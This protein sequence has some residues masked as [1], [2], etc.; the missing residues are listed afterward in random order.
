MTVGLN[1]PINFVEFTPVKER[2]KLIYIV[3]A[4]KVALSCDTIQLHV[5]KHINIE[6]F[7]KPYTVSIRSFAIKATIKW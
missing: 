3:V 5:T 1:K 6:V 4:L 2:I 7:V